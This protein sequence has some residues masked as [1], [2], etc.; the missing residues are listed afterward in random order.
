MNKTLSTSFLPVNPPELGS[1]SGFSHG[2]VA[3]P[4]SRVVFVAG[5]TASDASGRIAD[6]TFPAQFEAALSHVIAVVAAAGGRPEDIGRMLIFVT[7]LDGYLAA[8]PVLG[9]IWK[10]LMGAHYPAISLVEVSR[11]VEP[12]AAVEIEAT[13]VLPA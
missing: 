7:D 11:L 12:A 5:Q 10:R 8:R 3:P 6:R 9:A 1:P 13:A 4:G 2:L